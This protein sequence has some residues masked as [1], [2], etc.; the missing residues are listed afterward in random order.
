[1]SKKLSDYARERGVTYRT[2]WNRYR[3]GRIDGAHM[4]ATGHVVIPDATPAVEPLAAIYARVSSAENKSN[5]DAQAERLVQYAIARGWKVVSITKE[6][7]SGVNDHRKKLAK[8]LTAGSWNILVVEHKDRLTRFGF[9]YLDTILPQMK[10]RIE[11]VNQADDQKTDLMQDLVAVIY[12]F[13]AQMYGLRRS[14]HNTEKIVACLK[15]AAESQ[16][17]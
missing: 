16:P 11:V 2:A 10:K 3:A 14:R 17:S 12:S 8:L 4:D 6:V 7:G 1:M 15:A 13:S 5:L 9:N